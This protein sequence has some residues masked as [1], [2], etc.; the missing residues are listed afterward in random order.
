MRENEKQL[1]RKLANEKKLNEEEQERLNEYKQ[2][3]ERLEAQLREKEQRDL[4]TKEKKM[5]AIDAWKRLGLEIKAL[6]GEEAGDRI[7]DPFPVG[8]YE[9]RLS[10]LPAFPGQIFTHTIHCDSNGFHIL[11]ADSLVFSVADVARIEENAARNF[12]KLICLLRSHIMASK[13]AT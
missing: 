1:L 13:Q 10:Q 2:Q 8:R 4:E 12:R 6:D 3:Q 9:I 5:I 11:E 7:A